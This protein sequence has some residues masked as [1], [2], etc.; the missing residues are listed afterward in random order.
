MKK[1]RN[2]LHL[3]ITIVT[4]AVIFSQLFAFNSPFSILQSI[5]SVP[6]AFAAEPTPEAS[7]SADLKDKL[8]QLQAEIAS[9]AA[10]LKLEISKKLQNKAYVGVI[11]VKSDNTLTLATATGT[12]IV[13]VNEFTD[14]KGK[15]KL[16]FA[17]LNSEDYVA[18]L[19]DVDDNDVLTAKRIVYLTQ[20]AD[21]KIITEGKLA[22]STTKNFTMVDNNNTAKQF[23][24]DSD[25][26]IYLDS[27][28]A[29]LADLPAD[30]YLIIV[31]F[32]SSKDQ[33][34]YA[35]SVYAFSPSKENQNPADATKSATVSPTN[36]PSPTSN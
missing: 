32:K 15:T 27:K 17:N 8:K 11:N 13:T 16:S 28:D 33:S 36:Q 29:K 26:N 24:I 3:F 14:Y 12:K 19:G 23:S 18:A 34:L 30:A 9:K 35:R 5:F 10:T 22:S 1:N 7:Q 4:L 21:Q 6:S 31:G 2:S 25:T 20:P